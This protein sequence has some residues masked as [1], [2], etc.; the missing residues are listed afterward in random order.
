MEPLTL[1]RALVGVAGFEPATS[2]SQTRRYN[3]AT[4]H[5]ETWVFL[6]F[7]NN[8]LLSGWLDSNLRPPRPKRGAITGL[9][10]TP[11]LI[12]LLQE[13]GGGGIR[14]LGTSYPVRMFSKHVV[15][16]THPPLR[17]VVSVLL[18]LTTCS[19]SLKANAN[20]VF[21]FPF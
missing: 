14:T 8:M 9:R 15:S 3:R 21:V 10:Y 2:S 7:Y 19:H 11:K 6:V 18:Y 4:L 5:P 1:L 13:S 17:G 12:L 16:A 20:L